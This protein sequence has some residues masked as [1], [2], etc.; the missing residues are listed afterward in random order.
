MSASITS[1]PSWNASTTAEEVAA[2]LSSHIAGKT[3]L[4]TGVTP[5]GL[6]AHF[7][8]VVAAHQ[9]KLLILASRSPAKI[10]ETAREIEAAYPGVAT[11]TL[12]LDLG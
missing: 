7:A 1:N 2:S 11:R 9:P 10:A 4:V 8:K 3:I 12:E 5:G 6:G